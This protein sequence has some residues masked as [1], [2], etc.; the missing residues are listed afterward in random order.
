VAVVFLALNGMGLGH[1][2]RST[3]VSQA[4][5]SIGERPVIFT[6]GRY[7]Y[8]ELA[9]FPVRLV[10][11]LWGATDEV[12]KQVSSEL[13]SMAA[14]SL[15][16]VLV[17]DT[18]PAPVQL[19]ASVRR[20]LLVRPTSFEYLVRLNQQYGAIYSAYLLCDS[21]DSPTW[22]YDEAQ[23]R[24][25]AGWKKWSIIGPLYRT[26]SEAEILEVRK[27]FDVSDD[28][29]L[30]VFTM[31]GGGV[32]VLDPKG[33]DVIRFL[34]LASQ[35]ADT[36]QAARP[37]ARMLF[38]RGPLFP[39]RIPIPPRFE[40]V[41]EEAHMPALLKIA[42][43][44]VIR[45]GFNTAWECLSA[46]TP[47]MPL[48]GTTYVEPVAARV[49]RMASLGLVPPNTESFWFD[50]QWRAEYRRTAAGIVAA[51]SG[52]ADP[53]Q[54]GRLIVDRRQARPSPRRKPRASRSSSAKPQIPL[55]IRIDDVVCKEPALCWLL[56]LLASRG[57]RASLEVVPYLRKIDEAF[58]HR[59]DPAGA[60]FEVSQHGYAHVPRSSDSGRRCEF[61][62][63]T[64]EPTAEERE[65]IARGNAQ[66]EKE[67]PKRFSG[68]FSPPFDALPPWLPATWHELGGAFVSCLH[69][70]SV[71]G[72]PLRVARAGVDVWDWNADRALSQDAVT[73]KMAVQLALD[74]HAGIVLHPRCLRDRSNKSHLLSLLDYLEEEG[75]ATVSLKDLALGKVEAAPPSARINPLR[76]SFVGKK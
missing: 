37:S 68:G 6:E 40:I 62:L 18:H 4:L 8:A 23:T 48:I 66:L 31:G 64:T 17:E 22:P 38:V 57:M 73:R 65:D 56:D 47:F 9:K 15:P 19:P 36:V 33:Q 46:G 2:I 27:R 7:R 25:L 54:V 70:N 52:A 34:R 44:A 45:A 60:L 5:A 24:Q 29:K 1:L 75:F 11:S 3:I 21:P 55:V 69:T 76:R 53:E 14:I 42:R 63:D 67:C 74:G 50:D 51:H 71:P 10:P 16:A 41:R 13:F 26:P 28:R 30:C 59:F 32:H 39:A 43:G 20:V 49:D 58:L 61:S 35:V 72:A 12:R